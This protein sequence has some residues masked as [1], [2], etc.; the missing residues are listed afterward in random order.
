MRACRK[1]RTPLCGGLSSSGITALHCIL[2]WH[3]AFPTLLILWHSLSWTEDK[4]TQTSPWIGGGRG[5][6]GGRGVR[7]CYQHCPVT[8]VW[9]PAVTRAKLGTWWEGS[10]THSEDNRKQAR[11][12]RQQSGQHSRQKSAGSQKEKWRESR[13]NKKMQ[14]NNIKLA[15][16]ER[17]ALFEWHAAYVGWVCVPSILNIIAAQQQCS[18]IR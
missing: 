10:A 3:P 9:L 13:K 12:S 5:G 16:G 7:V 8:S 15:I 17:V 4:D 14:N 18:D 6:R 11:D 2:I 1:G